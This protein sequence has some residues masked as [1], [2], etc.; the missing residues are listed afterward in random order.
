MKNIFERNRAYA[1]TELSCVA[2]IEIKAFQDALVPFISSVK[3]RPDGAILRKFN[4]WN[5]PVFIL[6]VHSSPYKYSVAKTADG[7]INQLRLLR[8]FD[9]TIDKCVGFTFPKFANGNSDN[10]SFVTKVT[11]SF[12]NYQFQIHLSPLRIQDVKKQIEVAVQATCTFHFENNPFLCFMRLSTQDIMEI[13]GIFKV[14]LKQV[15]TRHSILLENLNSFFKFISPS[16][17]RESFK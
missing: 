15:Q 11:V 7:V 6:E 4:C 9:S 17:E 8:C 14:E 10:R 2:D 3:C 13:M 5:I 1:R 12:K 16:P